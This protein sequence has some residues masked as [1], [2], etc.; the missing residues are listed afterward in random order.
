MANYSMVGNGHFG[1]SNNFLAQLGGI[2]DS[3]LYGWGQGM[4]FGNAL[5]DYQNKVYT[6]PSNVNRQIAQN[7]EALGAAEGNHYRHYMDNKVL[8]YLAGGGDP[9]APNS[10][11][12]GIWAQQRWS[13]LV[14]NA[15]TPSNQPAQPVQ[16]NSSGTPSVTP[17]TGGTQ[18]YINNDPSKN[19]GI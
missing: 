14:N 15:Q 8:S 11:F 12:N 9:T 13:Q 2:G 17:N 7:I 18:V 3:W 19:K 16:M 6:N 5:M 1:G 10:P 4:R